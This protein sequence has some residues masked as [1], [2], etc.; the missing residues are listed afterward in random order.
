MIVS[1]H[2]LWLVSHFD[3]LLPYEA[4]AL[5]HSCTCMPF[6]APRKQSKDFV[7]VGACESHQAVLEGPVDCPMEFQE[8][9]H[10]DNCTSSPSACRAR[11][12]RILLVAERTSGRYSRHSSHDCRPTSSKSCSAVLDPMIH[13][14][15][16]RVRALVQGPCALLLSQPSRSFRTE[17]RQ[18]RYHNSTVPSGR[19]GIKRQPRI[20][21]IR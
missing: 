2:A 7:F 9:C 16:L 8:P 10:N 3:A 1:P 14:G 18:P 12:K 13:L 15:T 11:S 17:V 21:T 20:L 5:P 4:H 19:A 6:Q